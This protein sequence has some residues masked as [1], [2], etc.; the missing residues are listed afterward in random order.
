MS[1]LPRHNSCRQNKGII[2]PAMLKSR[3][4]LLSLFLA[5]GLSSCNYPGLVDAGLA[6]GPTFTPSPPTSTPV[7]LAAEVNGVGIRLETFE[8]EI[9]RFEQEQLS[10]GI[11]LATLPDYREQ[12]LWALID[13]QLLSQGAEEAGIGIPAGEIEARIAAIQ[14]SLGSQEAFETWLLVNLYSMDE[15]RRAL[16]EEI[17]AAE[18]VARITA[19]VANSTEQVHARH[20]LVA[21][22]EEAE[23]LRAQIVAGEDF[24]ELAEDFSV[25]PSTGQVGGDLGWFPQGYL[26]WP[27]VDQVAFALEPGEL[28]QVIQSELGYHLVEIL[29]RGEHQLDFETRLF[30]Q[31]KAVQD[32]LIEQRREK[33]VQTFID[34]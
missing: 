23:N 8:N 26:L 1:H 27:E 19:S 33:V 11:D 4:L 34:A 9:I 13:L 6:P 12:I 7:P 22:Q 16:E 10:A 18:M 30:L 31:E 25:D 21:T 3:S 28:S 29:E 20:I 5:L 24:V 32:W 15:F 2:Q 17:L 14:S